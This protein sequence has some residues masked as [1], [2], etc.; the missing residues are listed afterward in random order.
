M[1]F[2]L[3]V[4][5][6]LAASAIAKPVPAGLFADHAILQRGRPVPVWGTADPGEDVTVAFAGK[7]HT[8]KADSKGRWI[9]RL[10]PMDAS[11]EPKELSIRGATGEP[12]VLTDLLVGEVWIAS[13]QSNMEFGVNGCDNA[14][15]EIAAANFPQIRQFAVPHKASLD[16]LDSVQGNWAICSPNTVG[17]FT[18]VG[19]F[20]ARDLYQKLG[21]P[22][23]IINSSYGGTPAEAWTSR[24]ALNTVPELKAQADD[25]ISRMKKAPAL[26]EAFPKALAAWETANGLEDKVNEGFKNGWAAMDFDDNSWATATV[27]FNLDTALKAKTGGVFWVRKAVDIPAE[28]AGKPFNLHLGYLAEQY[29]T[30]YFNGVEVGSIGREPPAFYTASRGY[31]IPGNLVKAG[32]NVIAVRFVSHTEKGGLYISGPR[33]QLPVADPMSVDGTWK[34]AIE[35]AFPA[36]SPEVLAARP[37]IDLIQMQ[38]TS[39]SLFNGMINPIIPY[40]MRGVIWYQGESN[41]NPDDIAILYK[42]LFPLMIAD[43][44]G[45]WNQGDFPFGFVQ[46]ANFEEALRDHRDSSWAVLREAQSET[47]RNSPNTGMAVI[48]DIGSKITIHPENKQD[49]GKRLA[50]WARANTYGE[51]NLVFQSP[52]YQSHRVEGGKI[53]VKIDTGGSPLMIGKKSGL[54]PVVATPAN[55]L[56]WFEIAGADG[57]FVWA[58]A[59][60][61]G[62]IVEV[63]SPEVPSPTQ[64]R[65]AWATNPEGCNLYNEAGLPAS[66]FR[67]IRSAPSP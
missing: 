23:G 38:L 8:T 42:K 45:R 40:A 50:L 59:V 31:T 9:V 65:Y 19:Y 10:D 27:G 21:V 43:W 58:E 56:E 57:K 2:L 20:F 55:K 4:L 44:R 66:P 28:A 32:R 24:Q 12:V 61:V 3:L 17:G 34:I 11:S 5:P 37:K 26:L 46:L 15:V 13:G 18:G 25:L 60:I 48:I 49:V 53:Q 16:P 6:L 41:T 1:K 22:V 52:M 7:S 64:V 63:S 35:R 29:D 47:L 33:M 36:L 54:N 30:V 62:D 14:P 67:T 39:T 51:K